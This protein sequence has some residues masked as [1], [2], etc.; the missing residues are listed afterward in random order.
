MR[1]ALRLVAV[2]AMIG[3]PA[4][5]DFAPDTSPR[6]QQRRAAAPEPVA[7]PDV[8]VTDQGVIVRRS[9]KPRPRPVAP[10]APEKQVVAAGPAARVGRPE[11]R[12]DGRLPNAAR[13]AA[14]PARGSVCGDVSIRGET[15]P[16][17]PGRV[18]GCGVEAP[19]RIT[20]VAGVRLS[21]AA[22]M[23]C[24]TASA[25]RN[26]VV[27]G[28]NPAI[29]GRGGGISSLRI[30]AHY[31]CRGR[32]NNPNARIS[33]HGK[34]RAVDISALTL[35]DGT[36]ITVLNGWNS[37]RDG[38]ALRQMHRAACGTFGTVLGPEANAAHRDHFHFD[39]ARYRSGSYCR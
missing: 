36:S 3:A 18:E 23:D 10:T 35:A 11:E 13:Q 20:E 26:W 28:A 27:T 34:G 1:R 38:P 15:L 14:L 9:L 24:P 8:T 30:A 37:K 33:E 4:S 12:P 25:L 32:Y 39:T 22:T 2:L 21:T 19:V 5:A 29:G 16:P 31:I 17:I 7:G 6:P